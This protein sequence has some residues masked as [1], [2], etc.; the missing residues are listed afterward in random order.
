MMHPDELDIQQRL[1][2]FWSTLSEKDVNWKTFEE[3][4]N[5]ALNIPIMT[6]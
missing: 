6:D 2:N 3:T 1:D 4:N 5:R